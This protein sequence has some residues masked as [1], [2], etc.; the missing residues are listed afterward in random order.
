MM[1]VVDRFTSII[2]YL[3][4]FSNFFFF[5]ENIKRI[6]LIGQKKKGNVC[7]YLDVKELYKP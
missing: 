2:T 3:K 7:F 1:I 5:L 6:F 4:N